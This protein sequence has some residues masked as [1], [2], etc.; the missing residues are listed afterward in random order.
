MMPLHDLAIKLDPFC[1]FRYRYMY[2]LWNAYI[3]MSRVRWRMSL[4]GVGS[5]TWGGGR[6]AMDLTSGIV[7]CG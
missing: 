6:R 3:M 7:G 2:V 5:G 1:R 4:V